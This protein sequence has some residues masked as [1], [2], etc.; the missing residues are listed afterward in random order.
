MRLSLIVGAAVSMLWVVPGPAAQA[1]MDVEAEMVFQ[2]QRTDIFG[3]V[4]DL[5]HFEVTNNTSQPLVGLD[6]P[7]IRIGFGDLVGFEGSFYNTPVPGNRRAADT[8]ELTFLP[9]ND[10]SRGL[11]PGFIA[12]SF[13]VGNDLALSPPTEDTATRLTAEDLT[14]FTAAFG[15]AFVQPN[16]VGVVATLSVVAGTSGASI[17]D[18][19]WINGDGVVIAVSPAVTWAP[20]P[21]PGVSIVLAACCVGALARRRAGRLALRG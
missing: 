11:S 12:D 9:V 18:F 20:I 3:V 10:P 15:D 7:G 1:G 5:Y 17:G 6:A 4:F 14:V 19:E 2:G 8:E 16:S 21:E 13:F